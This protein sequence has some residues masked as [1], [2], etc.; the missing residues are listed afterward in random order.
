[1]SKTSL[2]ADPSGA[3]NYYNAL[4]AAT[5]SAL[6]G[7]LQGNLT[8]LQ[9]GSQGDFAYNFLNSNMAPPAFNLWSYNYTN[10]DILN[11]GSSNTNFSVSFTPPSPTNVPLYEQTAYVIGGV[12]VSPAQLPTSVVDTALA[13]A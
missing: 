10:A 4:Q 2:A 11:Q 8:P 12:I 7:I 1:M 5:Q 13:F 3:S 6:S 9:A